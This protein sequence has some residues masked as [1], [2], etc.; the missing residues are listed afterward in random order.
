MLFVD[1]LAASSSV[2]RSNSSCNSC[3]TSVREVPPARDTSPERKLK[4]QAIYQLHPWRSDCGNGCLCTYLSA[5]GVNPI[6]TQPVN[7]QMISTEPTDC[8]PISVFFSLIFPT[9]ILPW[10]VLVHR[11]HRVLLVETES[12]VPSARLTTYW[13]MSVDTFT[14]PVQGSSL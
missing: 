7:V 12:N 1:S 3:L 8:T 11:D 14:A 9:R 2:D 10:S 5:T 13:E 4:G 6:Q